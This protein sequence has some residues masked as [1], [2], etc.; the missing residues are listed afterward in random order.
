MNN[1]VHT[2]SLEGFPFKTDIPV[3][4]VKSESLKGYPMLTP[5]VKSHLYISPEHSV[6]FSFTESPPNRWW[7]FWQKVLLG[8]EWEKVG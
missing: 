4:V 5:V 8:W 7:R 1:T 6:I 3:P 2:E